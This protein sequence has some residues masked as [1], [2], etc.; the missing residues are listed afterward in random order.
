MLSALVKGESDL[1]KAPPASWTAKARC[2]CSR[3]GRDA[4]PGGV[5]TTGSAGGLALLRRLQVRVGRFPNGLH[6]GRTAAV[7][8]M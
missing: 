2:T 4:T 3:V 5:W 1:A 7:I 6:D 8:P